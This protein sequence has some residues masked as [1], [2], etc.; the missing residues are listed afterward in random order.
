MSQVPE[1]LTQVQDVIEAYLDLFRGEITGDLAGLR[2]EIC[3]D[4]ARRYDAL[5]RLTRAKGQDEYYLKA[6]MAWL[7]AVLVRHLSDGGGDNEP[8]LVSDLSHASVELKRNIAMALY[9]YAHTVDRVQ[10]PD[11]FYLV[12]MAV[13]WLV[14]SKVME[15]L[16]TPFVMIHNLKNLIF[17]VPQR[18]G[19]GRYW[20]DDQH[21]IRELLDQAYA[22][23]E[24]VSKQTHQFLSQVQILLLN[25]PEKT[26]LIL[27]DLLNLDVQPTVPRPLA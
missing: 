9:A 26:S 13:I 17:Q 21:S 4:K 12:R 22:V 2:P 15:E 25:Q 8:I 16:P 24:P 3:E 23:S 1:I 20:F 19:M 18:A 11:R 10:Q 27:A 6:S 7:K 14:D 5:I